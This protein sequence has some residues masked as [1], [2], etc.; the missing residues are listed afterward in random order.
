MNFK[1]EQYHTVEFSP[2]KDVIYLFDKA[3]APSW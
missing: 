1:Y 2:K 3:D